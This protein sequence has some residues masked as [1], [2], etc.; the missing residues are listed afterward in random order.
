MN[1]VFVPS[2][3]NPEILV[4]TPAA[5]ESILAELAATMEGLFSLDVSTPAAPAFPTAAQA[6]LPGVDVTAA[7]RIGRTLYVSTRRGLAELR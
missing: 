6:G 1:D 2:D 3:E 7:V 5:A 4:M